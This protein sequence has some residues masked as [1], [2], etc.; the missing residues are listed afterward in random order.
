MS[1]LIRLTDCNLALREDRQTD[2]ETCDSGLKYTNGTE[3]F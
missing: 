2:E 3:N 1:S